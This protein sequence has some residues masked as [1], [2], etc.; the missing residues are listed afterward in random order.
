MDLTIY[1]NVNLLNKKM[2][3]IKQKKNPGLA[4]FYG[5]LR[6]NYRGSYNRAKHTM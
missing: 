2:S 3:G 6:K 4:P 5:F 1:N